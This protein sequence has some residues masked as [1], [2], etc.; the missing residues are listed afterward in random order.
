MPPKKTKPNEKCP[1]G[2]GKKYKKCCM[3]AGKITSLATSSSATATTTTAAT[4]T[5]TT[6]S[7]SS[8]AVSWTI[9]F[10]LMDEM[11]LAASTTAAANAT[12]ITPDHFPD[13]RA[14]S[15]VINDYLLAVSQRPEAQEEFVRGHVEYFADSNFGRYIFAVCTSWYLKTERSA[16]EMKSLLCRAMNIQYLYVPEPDHDKLNYRAILMNIDDRGFINCLATVLEEV[17]DELSSTTST[18]AATATPSD[19]GPCFHGITSDH[20][21]NGVAYRDIIC[22]YLTL[23]V[24]DRPRFTDDHE[25]YFTDLNFSRYVFAVCT[26]WYLTMNRTTIDMIWLLHMAIDIKYLFVVLDAHRSGG[27]APDRDK[28]YRYYLGIHNNADDRGVINCLSRETKPFCDCMK[29]KKTEADGMDKIEHCVGCNNIFPRKDMLKCSGCKIALF[30]SNE[31]Q[32]K[33]WLEHRKDCKTLEKVGRS[34]FFVR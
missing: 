7:S 16:P 34:S 13:G 14:Y 5:T 24:P 9:L 23:S 25:E 19:R 3:V 29:V 21:L 32:A 31:C 4:T 1:C 33:D 15:D 12:T 10:D 28:L 17:M 18:S 2:S 26:S 22:D 11:S 20:F 8:A 27:P 30:C 6:V